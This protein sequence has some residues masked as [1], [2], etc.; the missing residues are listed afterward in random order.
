MTESTQNTCAEFSIIFAFIQINVNG[1]LSRPLTQL[2][3][4]RQD[5][6][7]SPI[8]S[9]LAF[10]PLFVANMPS[11]KLLAYADYLLVLLP[12]PAHLARLHTQLTNYSATFNARISLRKTQAFSL[13]G[14][15]LP[16]RYSTLRGDNVTD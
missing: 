1:F 2:G 14:S 7:L 12:D 11:I 16:E 13:F 10:G 15:P 8:L 6:P 5:D 9:N 3:G 4:L